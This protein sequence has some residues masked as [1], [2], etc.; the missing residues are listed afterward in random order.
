MMMID[1]SIRRVWGRSRENKKKKEEKE[2][3]A[4]AASFFI[5]LLFGRE[6][7]YPFWLSCLEKKDW[8]IAFSISFNRVVEV[9]SEFLTFWCS[10]SLPSL[11]G[12][13][14]RDMYSLVQIAVVVVATSI[15]YLLSQPASLS[16]SEKNSSKSFWCIRSHVTFSLSC[17]LSFLRFRPRMLLHPLPL[18]G[19]DSNI[20]S[21]HARH[22][23]TWN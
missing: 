2:M 11:S 22:L 23:W 19:R 9:G 12:S 15:C 10:F 21:L 13:L 4:P 1:R 16:L 5:R 14:S 3:R 8:I 7:S 6:S 17:H 18:T 20:H